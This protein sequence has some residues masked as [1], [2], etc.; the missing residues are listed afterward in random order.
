MAKKT[1]LKVIIAGGRD[2][3]SYAGLEEAVKASGFDIAEVVSGGAKGADSLGESWAKNNKIPVKK[4]IPNWN[5]TS[6]PDA[7]VKFRKNPWNDKEECY[8]WNAG[9]M[10]NSDMAKYADALIALPGDGGT[11][12]MIKKAKEN[13]IKVF[14]YE[15]KVEIT[16]E[17]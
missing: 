6:H 8:C 14:I 1:G 3:T 7:I 13:N 2:Y 12:D 16:N 4:F 9:F 5:D 11:R 17:F 10:R 15:E